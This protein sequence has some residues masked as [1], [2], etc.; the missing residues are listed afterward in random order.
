MILPQDSYI[1]VNYHY[2]EDP[3]PDWGGIHPCSVGE[4]ERQINFLSKSFEVVPVG[5]VF[6][7]AQ[8]GRKGKFCAITFD[9]GLK[10]QYD[11]AVPILA[12][13]GVAGTFFPITSTFENRL[14]TT[15]KIHILLSCLSSEK[16]IDIFHKFIRE[17]YPD[18]EANYSIPTNRRLFERRPHEDTSTANFKETMISLP[19]DIKDRFL[20][21]CFKEARLEEEEL[22]EQIFMNKTQ[23]ADLCRQEQE[24]GSHSH[25]HY[26]MT[27][28]GLEFL[29]K[30]IRL[31]RDILSSIS[32]KDVAV[33]SYPHGHHSDV[34][35]KILMENGFDYAVTIERRS[36]VPKDGPWLLPRYDANDVRDFLD[37][38]S[39]SKETNLA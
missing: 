27:A 4:F 9:D 31:S 24:V 8:K 13:Y 37:D 21:H 12:K 17:F 6:D 29:R 20:N 16:L 18:C 23:I 34:G 15:H 11:N 10:G 22:S 30:D 39:S 38:T 32:G 1:I 26:S 33:F 3:R 14:P 19:K 36:M 25:G 2:V 5:R 28:A 7:F 35:R